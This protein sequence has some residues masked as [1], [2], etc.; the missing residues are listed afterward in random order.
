[1]AR[2]R[3]VWEGGI[4]LTTHQTP[5]VS[6]DVACRSLCL[7]LLRACWLCSPVHGINEIR[8]EDPRPFQSRTSHKI[9]TMDWLLG[10]S[11]IVVVVGCMD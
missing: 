5:M 8:F 9:Q 4:Q 6:D 1:M 3:V 11:M 7:A 10:N 2:R